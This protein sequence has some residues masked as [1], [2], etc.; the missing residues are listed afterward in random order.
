MN[1]RTITSLF[2]SYES[3]S[4]YLECKGLFRVDRTESVRLQ[5]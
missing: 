3:E 2:Y 1:C 4:L 5:V